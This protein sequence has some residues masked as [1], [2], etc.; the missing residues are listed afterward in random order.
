M[1]THIAKS[2]TAFVPP[3]LE[4]LFKRL[5]KLHRQANQFHESRNTEERDLASDASHR[6]FNGVLQ[7]TVDI[8]RPLLS[9]SPKTSKFPRATASVEAIN[10][11]EDAIH[12][13]SSLN[14][15]GS[16][17][18]YVPP[19]DTRVPPEDSQ[20]DAT[21]EQE[22]K[23]LPEVK[24]VVVEMNEDQQEDEFF[25]LIEMFIG[26]IHEI[27][28]PLI[29]WWT[30][31]KAGTMEL[32]IVA[33]LTNVAIDLVRQAELEFEQFLVRPKK[34]PAAL[35]PVSTLPILLYLWEDPPCVIC[36]KGA[37]EIFPT[38]DQDSPFRHE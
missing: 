13:F 10:L 5:L 21:I 35:F 36:L 8:L 33:V 4:S 15:A 29:K 28:E 16:S 2:A 17:R 27:R 31:Y 26:E 34:F 25:V 22:I 1:A 9:G 7:E 24:T 11:V 14:I 6:Y 19:I 3:G 18:D 30:A 32:S 12:K 23:R 38:I 20:S 37:S